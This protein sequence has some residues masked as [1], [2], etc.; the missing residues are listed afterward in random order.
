MDFYP[1]PH[2][3]NFIVKGVLAACF[4]RASVTSNR[5]DCSPELLKTTPGYE[6]Q[7]CIA[8]AGG[9]HYRYFS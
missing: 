3:R 2:R 5:C 6:A 7:F 1:S 8:L 9:S 4:K